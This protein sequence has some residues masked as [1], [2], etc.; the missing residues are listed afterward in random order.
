MIG[1]DDEKESENSV[2][3]THLDGDEDF[4]IISTV[5]ID[6]KKNKCILSQVLVLDNIRL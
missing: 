4:P 1:M 5:L 3:S 2:L 6:I